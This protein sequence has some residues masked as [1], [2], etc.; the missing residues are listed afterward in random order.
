MLYKPEGQRK[1]KIQPE[2][3]VFRAIRAVLQ[4]SLIYYLIH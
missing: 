1:F 3:D 4:F 2:T